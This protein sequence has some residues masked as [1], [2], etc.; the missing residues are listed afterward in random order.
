[1]SKEKEKASFV[2]KAG[3]SPL[4]SLMKKTLIM[5]HINYFHSLCRHLITDE[6]ME[7]QFCLGIWHKTWFIGTVLEGQRGLEVAIIAS[8]NSSLIKIGTSLSAKDAGKVVPLRK[9]RFGNIRYPL[10]NHPECFYTDRST[11]ETGIPYWKFSETSG[12]ERG[13][14]TTPT[15][16]LLLSFSQEE[17][18]YVPIKNYS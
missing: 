1:M 12:V 18:V 15:G 9:E 14:K 11:N 16:I 17:Q 3:C 13:V 4:F 8:S 7:R 2:L 6:G 5:E 10:G